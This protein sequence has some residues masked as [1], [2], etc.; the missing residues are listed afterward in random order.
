MTEKSIN[1]KIKEA[2]S[3]CI[4][5]GLG[6]IA[7]S[8]AG[9]ILVP[10]YA[11]HL[12]PEEYGAFSLIQMCGVIASAIF[13]LGVSSAL[14]RS[15]FD[16]KDPDERIKVFNTTLLLLIVGAL[17]QVFIGLMFSKSISKLFVGST[18]YS[19]Y[20]F[21]MLLANAVGF[22][23]IGF[24]VYF[25]LLRR[26]KI[27]VITSILNLVI[28]VSIAYYLLRFTE[29]GIGAPVY[30][31]LISQLLIVSFFSYNLR[32]SI[33]PFRYLP[34]EISTQLKYGIPMAIAS[35][36]Q[37]I[38]NWGDRI[39]LNN[40]SST[41]DVGIYSLGVKIASVYNIFIMLPFVMIWNPMMMDY[42]N[43]KNVKE[44]FYR[45]TFYYTL[46]S[47]GAIVLAQLF[48]GD[49]LKLFITNQQYHFSLT[50]VPLVITGFFFGSLVNIFSAGILYKRKSI[51]L[52]YIYFIWGGINILI[53]IIMI[54]TF[55]IWGAVFTGIAT[56]MGIALTMLIISKKY[57][58]FPFH[59]VR[60][61][62]LASLL[63]L[64]F[65]I[66]NVI[67]NSF[68]SFNLIMAKSILLLL[69]IFA[70]F[71]FILEANEK[72]KISTIFRKVLFKV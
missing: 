4:V 28:T 33:S 26:S 29:L 18:N 65:V 57:F 37:M 46:I 11:K 27:V 55:Q 30:A 69:L 59:I 40:L 5:Y 72:K 71:Y 15:Y 32:G 42:R 51:I 25:R 19:H 16:Y 24:L 41:T 52:V 6:S 8:A 61:V 13:Y 22:I 53:N 43:D 38:S 64:F 39:I 44:L 48:L 60:Y 9:F 63:L 56:R 14:P 58:S 20:V 47:V 36:G 17:F 21:I 12:L 70:T 66:E 34:K 23:N 50:I 2:I 31:I 3:H 7:Q 62:R 54:R 67:A 1:E 45:I 49:I 68:S 35:L 10:L